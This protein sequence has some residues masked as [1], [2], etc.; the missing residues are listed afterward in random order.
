MRRV[1]VNDAL[2]APLARDASRSI[3]IPGRQIGDPAVSIL[4]YHRF[5]PTVTD[6][7]TVRTATFRWQLEYL[8]HHHHPIVPLRAVVS[9]LLGQSPAP[10]SGAVVITADDG[11]RS[12]YTEMLPIVR[13]YDLPVTLF[14]YPSAI[15][16]A[17]YAMTWE[18]LE[19]LHRTG[20]FDIESHTYWHPN[21]KTEK[22]KLSPSAYRASVQMQLV[23]ASTVL[24]NRLG[25]HADLLAWPFGVYDDELIGMAREAGYSGAF[26]IER[27]FVTSREPIM[28]LPRFLVTDTASGRNFTSMLPQE[29]R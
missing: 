21:F 13:A 9:Y 23:K 24:E 22:Q 2:A 28:A 11:H 18:Q 25:V 19:A 8:K 4:V 20:L 29:S 27:R 3:H 26:T 14:I 16:N 12:V 7:M 6:A 1:V 10:P 5:A 15:S 17:S